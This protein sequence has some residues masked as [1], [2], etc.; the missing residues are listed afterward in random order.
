MWTCQWEWDFSCPM[1]YQLISL[2]YG[3]QTAWCQASHHRDIS[4]H[5]SISGLCSMSHVCPR[6]TVVW[7]CW[8]YGMSP[9]QSGLCAGLSGQQPCD[10]CG[11]VGGA[12]YIVGQDCSRQ[13]MSSYVLCPYKFNVM[14]I[15]VA[16]E[17]MRALTNMGYS[18]Y[19]AEHRGMSVP[20]QSEVDCTRKGLWK[21]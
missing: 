4:M 17:S 2:L 1:S 10:M 13:L 12:I 16:P 6:I 3:F 14:N 8:W 20:L 21:L 5:Q 11:F 9:T 19:S 7:Q 18:V 15:L